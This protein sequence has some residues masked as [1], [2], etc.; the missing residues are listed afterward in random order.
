MSYHPNGAIAQFTYGNGVLH[1]MTQNERLLPD[2]SR[3][4]NGGI[5]ILDD[6]YDYDANGNVVAI[7]DGVAG[8]RGSRDMT[9]DDLD[10]L[11][12]TTSAGWFG[13]T[14]SYTYDVLDNIQSVTRPDSNQTYRYC[15]NTSWQLEFLRIGAT[16]ACNTGP[17]AYALTYDPQGNLYQKNAQRYVF[18]Q[19]N[20]LRNV[21]GLEYYRYDGYGRRTLSWSPT[22]GS[23]TY[24]YGQ[25]GTLRYMQDARRGKSEQ[26]VYLGGSLVAIREVAGSTTTIKYQHTDA[27]GSPAAVTD[28]ARGV[29]E[30]SEREPY[31]K[32]LNRPM[33]DGPGFTGHAEDSVTGLT[34]MQQ[35]YYDPQLGVF[36][37]VDPISAESN[38]ISF[39]HRYKYANNNPFKFT[40]P[41]GRCYTSTGECMTPQEFDAAWRNEGR[42][43]M[44]IVAA[45]AVIGAT[46]GLAAET[47]AVGSIGSAVRS[48][49]TK[50]VLC[51]ALSL[52]DCRGKSI[53]PVNPR[54]EHQWAEDVARIREALIRMIERLRKESPVEPAPPR[55]PTEPTPTPPPTQTP[56]PQEPPPMPRPK[57]EVRPTTSQG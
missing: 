32:L 28:A 17:A 41:D 42:K 25:D 40:D 26:Y 13:G 3:D 18:T 57:P 27:L 36:Y 51:A 31:G 46:G 15:Y 29:V 6:Y 7:T 4:Y 20:R 9:Y 38:P 39:F 10:R 2:R 8:N 50:N 56:K 5:A 1:V 45:P 11:K 21:T 30:R 49:V 54:Q 12:S 47:G 43:V 23:L 34:Y 44:T 22:L 33:H 52:G 24:V 48:N 35:R 53:D 37:S 19:D 16:T 14:I 55:P